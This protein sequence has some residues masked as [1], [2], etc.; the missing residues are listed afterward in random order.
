MSFVVLASGLVV[1]A[2]VSLFWE[3]R[4]NRRRADTEL[5]AFASTVPAPLTDDVRRWLRPQLA[6]RTTYP[7]IGVTVGLTAANVPLTPGWHEVPWYWFAIF[8]GMSIGLTAG[9]LVAGYRTSPL[10]DGS[11]RTVDPARRRV[12]DHYDRAQVLRLRLA[13]VIS[14]AALGLAGVVA[15]SADTAAGGRALAGCALGTVLVAAHYVVAAAVI[16][17]PMVASTSDGLVWQRA[18]LART[19]D[20]MPGSALLDSLVCAA[21][22]L[23]AV[24]VAVRDLSW[25]VILAGAVFAVLTTV[26]AA[27]ALRARPRLRWPLMR[28]F[29]TTTAL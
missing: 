21:I 12:P 5:E 1:I 2:G 27:V 9:T 18:L 8:V 26:S 15:G 23:L 25:P 3:L 22:A 29:S 20:P 6:R 24:A 28:P 4:Y 17:R 11:V 13:V 10:L 16:S 7:A 19:L 14:V